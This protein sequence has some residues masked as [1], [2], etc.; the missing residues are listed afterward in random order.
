MA[1]Y[2]TFVLNIPLNPQLTNQP[3][4][5]W[6]KLEDAF[7]IPPRFSLRECAI[8]GVQKTEAVCMKVTGIQAVV[9]DENCDPN[10]RPTGHT[11][12]CNNTP[13]PPAYVSYQSFELYILLLLVSLI[14]RYTKRA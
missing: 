13:C 4:N 5:V 10:L 7:C 12:T 9:T 3:T 2:G 1:W 11:V 8:T 6:V 14:H